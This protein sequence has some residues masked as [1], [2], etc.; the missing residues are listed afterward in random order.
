M[1]RILIEDNYTCPRCGHATNRKS[2]IIS[3]FER[4]TDCP[5]KIKD[6]V[7]T[8]RI[9]DL[10]LKNRVYVQNEIVKD[11]T[12]STHIDSPPVVVL[13]EETNI[14]N[15]TIIN[16]V[17]NNFTV[18]NN[19]NNNNIKT[20]YNN[21]NLIQNMVVKIDTLDKLKYLLD[22]NNKCLV[23]FDDSI[24]NMF[25]KHLTYL[26]DNARGD[27]SMP[28]NQLL[29]CVDHIT[30]NNG[31]FTNFNVEYCKK[32]QRIKIFND[33]EWTTYLE[34]SGIEKV[35]EYLLL[36][37]LN[38]YELYLLTKIHEAM[39]SSKILME[40][41]LNIYYKFLSIFDILPHADGRS[42]Q[43]LVGRSLKE[44]N[45][46]YISDFGMKL[47]FEQKKKLSQRE[48]RETRKQILMIIKTNSEAN[49]KDL[50]LAL[51]KLLVIDSEYK[52]KILA[53]LYNPLNSLILQP[54][55]SIETAFLAIN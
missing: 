41:R 16:N 31:E 40:E 10:V 2:N 21:Y 15:Q 51:I 54:K 17:Q 45:P 18:T 11:S 36:N 38:D 33:G 37:Y 34:C 24:E 22:Y 48:K 27:H 35:V 50:N 5:P 23:S 26:R 20:M 43:L 1:P 12:L 8:D 42:D 13:Q 29:Q 52:E 9:K 7:L 30:R 4:K 14:T 46:Y 47:Y 44:G 6:I 49:V 32:E 19:N 28:E 25:Q 3:H 53:K 55:P 39:C